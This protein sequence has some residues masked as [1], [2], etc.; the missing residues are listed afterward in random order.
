MCAS[1]DNAYPLART[2]NVKAAFGPDTQFG[3]ELATR[4]GARSSALAVAPVPPAGA[5]H[6]ERG[7]D[8]NH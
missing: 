3:P 7:V 5:R 4:Q 1:T 8:A 6:H 2:F